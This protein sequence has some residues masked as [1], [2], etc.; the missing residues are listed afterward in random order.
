M[1]PKGRQLDRRV[2]DRRRFLE[3]V[4][5]ALSLG[6]PQ[7]GRTVYWNLSAA[8]K[9]PCQRPVYLATLEGQKDA[10]GY[11]PH[12]RKGRPIGFIEVSG[13]CRKC[14]ACGEYRRRLWIAKAISEQKHAPGRTWF[15]T[16]TANPEMRRDVDYRAKGLAFRAGKGLVEEHKLFPWRA[17]VMKTEGAA[18]MKRL[19]ERTSRHHTA[20][21]ASEA[22]RIGFS[23]KPKWRRLRPRLRFMAVTEA[24]KDGNCHLH[25][26]IH[27]WT[28]ALPCRW[29]DIEAAWGPH[30]RGFM[31]AELVKGSAAPYVSKYLGKGMEATVHASIRYGSLTV[32]P[33]FFSVKEEKGKTPP[34]TTKNEND[35]EQEESS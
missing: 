10:A 28:P 5:R 13:R 23:D 32:G 24:H 30:M 1:T 7:R 6:S 34:P 22:S 29:V 18:F 35:N 2:L 3:R 27:E 26:L 14:D 8:S 31:T 25:L 12:P 15:V 20:R 4:R 9:H 16:L 21:L 11:L 19:R 17:R 33:S